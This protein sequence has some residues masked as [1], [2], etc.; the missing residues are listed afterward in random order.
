MHLLYSGPGLARDA[1]SCVLT[2]Q[3]ALNRDSEM[4]TGAWTGL[5]IT[6]IALTW[7][8]IPWYDWARTKCHV[9]HGAGTGIFSYS[10]SSSSSWM[11]IDLFTWCIFLD[12]IERILQKPVSVHELQ[13]N[14]IKS[15]M[16][17]AKIWFRTED[18]MSP[19]DWQVRH[20]ASEA[21]P[22]A[23]QEVACFAHS[24]RYRVWGMLIKSFTLFFSCEV[25]S[26]SLGIVCPEF[27]YKVN[28][29]WRIRH[30]LRGCLHEVT[31][32]VKL[33]PCLD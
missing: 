16:K 10:S 14:V 21:M 4:Q 12:K 5:L 3:F 33:Q 13:L 29:W 6:Q 2:A 31:L 27:V 26:N 20:I 1:E 24:E 17:W 25:F 7:S 19:A 8:F 22:L 9:P 15:L 23:S 11:Q 28:A 18:K 32:L 30:N